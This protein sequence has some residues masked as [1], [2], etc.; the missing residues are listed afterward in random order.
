MDRV[1]IL[2]V[3]NR[4]QA[5]AILRRLAVEATWEIEFA[6]KKKKKRGRSSPA[7]SSHSVDTNPFADVDLM[8]ASLAEICGLNANASVSI[9]LDLDQPNFTVWHVFFHNKQKSLIF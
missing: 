9:V 4:A 8:K 3:L 1:D 5:H 7:A 2:Y 6:S